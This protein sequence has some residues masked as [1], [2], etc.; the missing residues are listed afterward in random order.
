MSCMN[1]VGKDTCHDYMSWHSDKQMDGERL[2][3]GR[4]VWG[5]AELVDQ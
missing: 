2:G 1:C 4:E 5:S 3:M